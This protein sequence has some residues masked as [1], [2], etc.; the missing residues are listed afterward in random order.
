M[1]QYDYI[2]G[3]DGL[4][5]YF[6]NVFI[7]TNWLNCLIGIINIDN[8]STIVELT[9]LKKIFLKSTKNIRVLFISIGIV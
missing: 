1:T 7:D 3:I 6:L 5:K 4:E 2:V 9:A 8:M